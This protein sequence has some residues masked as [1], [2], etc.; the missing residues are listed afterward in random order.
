M[1]TYARSAHIFLAVLIFVAV[2]NTWASALADEQ[3]TREYIVDNILPQHPFLAA[4]LLSTLTQSRSGLSSYLQPLLHSEDEASQLELSEVIDA[5]RPSEKRGLGQ[6]IHNCIN[7]RG[8]MN[9]IQCKSM[10]H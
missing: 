10:C 5:L 8:N 3:A 1:S 4:K 9:F 6:C 2:L 7:G